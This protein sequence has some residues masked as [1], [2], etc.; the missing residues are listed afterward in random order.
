[1]PLLLPEQ[2]PEGLLALEWEEFDWV[3]LHRYWM[4]VVPP[5]VDFAAQDVLALHGYPD[6]CAILFGWSQGPHNYFH[7]LFRKLDQWH[8]WVIVLVLMGLW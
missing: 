8:Q 5:L 4:P 6:S 2:Q 1:M 7:C 3:D